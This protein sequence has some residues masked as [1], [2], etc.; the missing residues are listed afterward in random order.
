[1]STLE[2]REEILEIL[3][4]RR[5]ETMGNLASELNVTRRTIQND[6]V[7][8]SCFAPIY[9]VRGR[10]GGGV[11]LMQGFY[12]YRRYLTDEQKKALTD[13]INGQPPNCEMLQSII[14][15]FSKK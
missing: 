8:L 4:L 15:T 5:F 2:R 13:V 6:I 12:L 10:Y 9:T 1:M 7:A 11:C 14:N 3:S